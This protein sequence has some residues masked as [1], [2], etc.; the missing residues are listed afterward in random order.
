MDSG[1]RRTVAN[2]SFQ[3]LLAV[4]EVASCRWSDDLWKIASSVARRSGGG[5]VEAGAALRELHVAGYLE[6]TA[7]YEGGVLTRKGL[8]LVEQLRRGAAT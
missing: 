6:M 4:Y 2:A 1:A 5:L 8:R 7:G 3:T